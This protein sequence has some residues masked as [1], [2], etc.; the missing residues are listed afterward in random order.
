MAGTVIVHGLGQIQRDLAKSNAQVGKAMRLG[1][2]EAAEP[3][4]RIAEQL[5]LARI[6]RMP[7]SPQWAETRIGVTRSA[8]YI[9]PRQ[10]G[11]R[12]NNSLGSRRRPTLVT[13]MMGR[14]F[15]PALEAGADLAEA[16]VSRLLGEVAR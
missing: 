9:V 1:L 14:S 6:R 10:R 16:S 8:V 7:F 4:S 15:E 3:T 12:V 2:R 13:L 11:A 5:S